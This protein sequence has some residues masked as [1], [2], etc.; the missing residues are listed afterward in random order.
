MIFPSDMEPLDVVEVRV[1]G[2]MIE[3]EGT[4]PEYYPL[5]LNALVNACN[6]K[7][8]RYPVVEYDDRDVKDALDRL[9]H[10]R[11][12]VAI[13]GSGRVEKYGQRISET[14]NLGRRELAVLC[15]LLLRGPQ[16]L[17]EVKDR[18]ERMYSFSDLEETERVLDKLAEWPEIPLA[19][20]LSKQPGQK[21]AR[22]AHLLSGEPAADLDAGSAPVER[23]SRVEVLER[24]VAQLREEISDLR[25][26]LDAFE[27]QF[28]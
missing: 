12:A 20:R 13:S 14:L 28:K 19:K 5:T 11:M 23:G 24:D 9:R 8:N 17:G 3:K 7:S 15:V 26:R 6:Q 22:Y 25:R 10:K 18:T 16:T 2:A 27:N 1:L 21:E 4:T